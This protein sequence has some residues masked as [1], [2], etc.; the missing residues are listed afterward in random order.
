MELTVLGSSSSGNCY[1]LQN[2]SEALILECGISVMEVKKA[3]SFNVSKIVGCIVTHDH[4]DHAGYMNDFL[5]SRIQVHAS[6]GTVKKVAPKCAFLPLL[7]QAGC[8]VTIGNFTVMPFDVKHDAAEPLGFVINHPEMG[9]TL[10]ATDCCYLPYTFT[11]LRNVLIECNYSEKDIA[12]I[13]MVKTYKDHILEGHLSLETCKEALLANDLSKVN[14]IVL[15]HLSEKNSN[16]EKFKREIYLATGKK[17]H[18]ATK[19]LVI[20]F[21]KHPF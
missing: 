13:E 10:F 3:V 6:E 9:V 19:N 21:N 11:N 16:E 8:K 4:N 7:L 20:N 18:V 14:N 5:K 12:E 1:V 15:I 2:E 17:V